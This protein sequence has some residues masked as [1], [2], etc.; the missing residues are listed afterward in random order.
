M[1]GHAY[2]RQCGCYSCGLHEEELERAEGYEPGEAPTNP[3]LEMVDDLM[4]KMFGLPK[5]KPPIAPGE[6]K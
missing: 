1:S 4:F 2:H 6:R 3:N 5:I